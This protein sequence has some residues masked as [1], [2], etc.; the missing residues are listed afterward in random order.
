MSKMDAKCFNCGKM[1]RQ[2]Y[3]NG[4][5]YCEYCRERCNNYDNY[6][7]QTSDD[8]A[9]DRLLEGFITEIVSGTA[10][11]YK[12]WLKTKSV[13]AKRSFAADVYWYKTPNF[14]RLFPEL[15]ATYLL[16]KMVHL[17][18]SGE[19]SRR[20]RQNELARESHEYERLDI[21]NEEDDRL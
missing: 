16:K 18:K 4:E 15:N 1:F 2:K 6:L 14:K 8:D 3:N 13:Y 12:R 9:I 11:K 19:W 17:V 7:I 20:N 10:N 5:I 21:K